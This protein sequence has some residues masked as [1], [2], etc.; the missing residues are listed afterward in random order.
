MAERTAVA[1]PTV[2]ERFRGAL[3]ALRAAQKSPRGVS[4]YSSRVNRPAGRVLAAAADAL[5]LRP[6]Q[7]SLLSGL[8][9]FLAIGLLVGL[10][11]APVQGLAV[12]AALLVGFAL[13]AA[14]GQLAR[15]RRT[16]SRTGEW[17]D[18][19]LD[20]AVKLGLH[21]AVLVAW[22]RLGVDGALL[23]VALGFQFVAVLLFFGGTLAAKLH[24]QGDR[25]ARA[26]G[27]GPDPRAE[28]RVPAVL[29]LPV[30]YGVIGLSFLLWGFQDTFRPVY[31]VLF[32]AHAAYLPAYARHWLRGLS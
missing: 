17:F 20:C 25:E 32:A 7:V 3:T 10:R 21:A 12:G 14:D 30:D 8:V 11:P 18:H 22:Y 29:L 16:G 31:I 13:D 24:E 26:T 1:A 6:N 28:S 2:P 19:V 15:L 23:L 5:G 4:P 27:V 9:S